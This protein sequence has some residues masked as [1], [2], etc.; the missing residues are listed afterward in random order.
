LTLHVN[1]HVLNY[2]GKIIKHYKIIKG[3]LQ[4]LMSHKGNNFVSKNLCLFRKR[5]QRNSLRYVKLIYILHIDI[6]NTINLQGQLPKYVLKHSTTGEKY[7][8]QHV[9]R[10]ECHFTKITQVHV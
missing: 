9:L 8:I 7:S 4:I 10:P 2:V 3:T 5:H 1:L 6:N